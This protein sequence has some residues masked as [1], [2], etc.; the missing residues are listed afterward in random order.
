M[1]DFQGTAGVFKLDGDRKT[2][3]WCKG[4]ILKLDEVP[5]LIAIKKVVHEI[6]ASNSMNLV[7]QQKWRF[8]ADIL[9]SK[10]TCNICRVPG[11]LQRLKVN[12]LW[13]VVFC[14]RL[15]QAAL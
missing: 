10:A 5:K 2:E 6:F 11:L 14:R 12:Y 4:T 3:T 8:F 13:L 9:P 15:A 1:C 7:R